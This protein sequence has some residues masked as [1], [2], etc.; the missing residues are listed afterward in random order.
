MK[1]GCVTA[2]IGCIDC[3]QRVIEE[4][5]KELAPIRE[6]ADENLQDMDTV[7]NII[8]EGCDR[9]RDVARETMEEVR[10]AIGIAYR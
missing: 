1:E 3:K 9:A 6:R 2:G 10:Q 5:Q 8:A 4:V 7:R